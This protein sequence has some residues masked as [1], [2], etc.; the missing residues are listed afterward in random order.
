MAFS[1]YNS[2]HTN[3]TT[4][5]SI[6]YT[7]PPPLISDAFNYNDSLNILSCY[8]MRVIIPTYTGPVCN[9]T[10]SSDNTSSDFYTDCSQNYFVNTIG[11]PYVDWFGSSIVYVNKWYDQ[12]GKNNHAIQDMSLNNRPQIST[13][14]NKYVIYFP[15]DISNN[16]YFI[17][18]NNIQPK[19][20]FVNMYPIET[21]YTFSCILQTIVDYGV[22]LKTSI[23]PTAPMTGG[24]YATSAANGGGTQIAYN[25]NI[26]TVNVTYNTWNS[27]AISIQNPWWTTRYNMIT[28][29]DLAFHRIAFDI[30]RG[31]AFNGYIVEM[32]FHNITMVSDDMTNFYQNRL[33]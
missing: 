30:N 8:S 17:F 9:L 7:V 13:K 28:Y 10:R 25:N 16:Y 24:W 33:I 12:S 1:S 2:I 31:R 6:I 29:N 22:R 27:F 5:S 14:D 20:V 23:F 19:T 21:T 26:S 11:M 3:L 18:T 32:I 15:N 4:T